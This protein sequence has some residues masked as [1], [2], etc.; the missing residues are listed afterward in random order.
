[1][2]GVEPWS[3][4]GNRRAFYMLRRWLNFREL[5]GPGQAY[6]YSLVALFRRCI[7]T[8]HQLSK[9]IEAS[10]VQA[11]LRNLHETMAFT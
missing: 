8:L 2:Q 1:M 9:R 4:Q 7:A 3:R 5:A 10:D 11:V 6:A